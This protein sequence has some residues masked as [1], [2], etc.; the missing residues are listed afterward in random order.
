MAVPGWI[1]GR[2][3]I[4][5][6]TQLELIGL[7]LAGLDESRG[8][9]VLL[10]GEPGI[11][12]TRLAE[13]TLARARALGA[14]TA[15]TTAW[16]G[17]GAPPLW[18][19][20]D[21]LRQLVGSDHALAN[22]SA[23]S[24][25]ASAAA[26]FAQAAAVAE[27]IRGVAS[28]DRLVAVIEDL[29]W[30]DA[31]SIRVL[32]FVAPAMRD[33][34]CLLLGTYRADEL[35]R[36]MG[37]EL[38]RAG[39]SIAVP[40]L[41]P[42]S[43]AELLR[44]SAGSG[45][46]PSAVDAVVARSGGNPLFVWEFG[47]LMAS[48]GRVDV[49]P[50]A[51]PTAVA[52]VI[53][54]RLARLSE[55]VVA[56]LRAAAVAGKS[57]TVDVVAAI[58]GRTIHDAAAGLQMAADA[59]VVVHV[60]YAAFALTHDVVR[61]VVL[62]GVEPAQRARLHERAATV[63]AERLQGDPSFHAVVA[64]HLDRAG[65]EH[66][67]AASVQWE[68]A[69]RR[70]LSV[71]AY[72]GAAAMFGRAARA[73][74]NDPA[75]RAALTVDEGDALLLAG[76]LDAARTRFA[77]G[78]D[79]ARQVAAPRLLARAVLG[80]G[81]GP[82]A[83]EVPIGS[84][85]HARTVAAALAALPDDALDLRSMLLARLSVTAASPET[86]EL[87]RQRAAEALDLAQQVGDER[88]IA[89]ALAAVNDAH[90]G[91]A[92]TMLRRDNA[93]TIVELAAAAGDRM[94]ELVGHRFRVVADLEL[95]DLASVDRTI[96]AFARLADELRQPLV[97]WYVPLFRGMRALL[98]GDVA[99]A[100]AYQHDVAATAGA[101]RSHNAEMLAATLLLGINA[102][103]GR[104]PAP[105][106]LDG[107]FDVDPADW[108]SYASGLAM[109]A[110]LSGNTDRARE[111]LKLH[112]DNGFA[113]LGDDAEHLTTL[114]LFGRV[115]VG[116]DEPAAA[117]GVY[118][119]L[120]PHAGLWSVDGIA[121]C[122][123]GPVDLELARIA[124]A[125]DRVAGAGAHL[126]QARRSLEEADTPL[127]LGDLEAL[128][129]RCAVLGIDATDTRD[130]RR[131]EAANVFR[132]EGQFWVL[133][134]RGRTVRMKDAK[135]LADLARLVA[136]PGQEIYVLDLTTPPDADGRALRD[137]GD[138]GELLDARARAEYRRRV[139]ELDDEIADAASNHDVGRA[140]RARTERDFIAAELAAALGLGGRPRRSGDPAERA[141][142][143]VSG[144]IRLTI[145]R[146][147]SEH[148]ELARHLTNAV[149]TGTF[150]VY[151]P[152]DAVDWEL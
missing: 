106:T 57:F 145:G 131:P 142:K 43:A 30:A 119:L 76:D 38:T 28:A 120:R 44:V 20:A 62:D 88:L 23:E 50:A 16:Q 84:A 17:E 49:A 53:E 24:P 152:E 51:V 111:L 12:K 82:V 129:R 124:V 33:V 68:L 19:W 102:A 35:D 45:V 126:T 144:R 72:P 112:A 74:A 149:R 2:G 135:G 70:A 8:A 21:L 59:G 29:Q 22:F 105:D 73:A 141:R 67:E 138:V 87:A 109:V 26:Q 80:V 95:G 69:A 54:R 78:V 10:T 18:P 125:L 4:G 133:A 61:D 97:S 101:T 118:E 1:A 75:R 92:Y 40:R 13:E 96:A 148:P 52:V 56:M 47:Q 58:G 116:L 3:L 90:G 60:D 121:G 71:L 140:E 77:A 107:L 134:Y 83:W 65:P 37:A 127:L 55:D 99:A 6:A 31:A 108:A 151:K 122:C 46:S 98:A 15:W 11:G 147:G 146:I 123:W 36:Q 48:S 9:L 113:R 7:H 86:M 114:T 110:W 143:A 94:L 100:E 32:L 14:R 137:A 132:R 89:Q 93:D 39:T 5:R 42:E 64:D 130:A 103:V 66:T 128:E 27:V 63:F 79:L 150:C 91:P 81:V 117:A 85:E 104:R 34:S 25:G 139:G 41:S 136:R 115:A